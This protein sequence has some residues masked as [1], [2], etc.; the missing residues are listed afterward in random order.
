MNSD[1]DVRLATLEK[2]G[3]D[4]SKNYASVYDID[5]AILEATEQGGGGGGIPEAPIDG[6]TYGR[7][8]E[9]WSE[10]TT[11]DL[12]NYATKS[13][14]N[15]KQDTINDLETIR[16]GAGL[17]STALQSVPDG[18]ATETWVGNQG[19]I[20]NSALSGY[21]TETWVGQQGYLTAVPSNYV[22]FESLTQAQ[23]D[24]L[25][26]KDPATLYIINDAS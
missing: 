25:P 12:S 1:Y 20:T 4:V 24:A 3:G 7:K 15:S 21:A 23:Y 9:A 14:L 22:K 19:Y 13:D 17:G 2:L 10:I 5:L 26:V 18:Y 11:P 16:T 8:N 6:K